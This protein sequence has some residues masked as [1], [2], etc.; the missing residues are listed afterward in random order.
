MKVPLRKGHA[1]LLTSLPA[2]LRPPQVLL[3]FIVTFYYFHWH[4]GSP[5]ATDQGQYDRL[6]FWEQVTAMSF[7]VCLRSLWQDCPPCTLA[8]AE[9]PRC[10]L[11]APFG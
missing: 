11:A 1:R 4:K 7:S 3:N 9:R 8:C 10:A 2:W 5:I 6:T